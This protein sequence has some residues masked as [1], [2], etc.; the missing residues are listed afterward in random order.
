MNVFDSVL[1][2][3]RVKKLNTSAGFIPYPNNSCIY[4]ALPL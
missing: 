4:P 1:T 2:L 3:D